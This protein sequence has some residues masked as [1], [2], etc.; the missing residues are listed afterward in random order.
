MYSNRVIKK[1]KNVPYYTA[2]IQRQSSCVKTR[3]ITEDFEKHKMLFEV[4]SLTRID[5]FNILEEYCHT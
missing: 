2:R 3:K 5:E 1:D 4:N